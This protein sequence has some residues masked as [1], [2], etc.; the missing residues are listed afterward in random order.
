MKTTSYQLFAQLCESFVVEVSSTANII[1]TLK[2]GNQVLKYLHSQQGLGHEQQ[3]KPIAKIAWSDLKDAY[4]GA[5]VI[6]QY[7]NGVGAIKQDRGSYYAVA[8]IGGEVKAYDDTRGGNILNFLKSEL[9]GNPVKM[10][11]GTETGKTKELKSKRKGIQQELEKTTVMNQD[12]LVQKFSPLW[13][14]AMTA[15]IADIKGMVSNMIKND[16]FEKAERKLSQLKR[17]DQGIMSLEAGESQR[18]D[19]LNSA[20]SQAIHMAAAHYYPDETG[21]VTKSYHGYS[22]QRP[23]GIQMLL[24]D[25]SSGDQKKLGAILSFFKRALI[26]G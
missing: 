1:G 12:T 26:T 18:P 20:I 24:K 4:R 3:Y 21:E 10:W 23:E 13:N 8:S 16:A 2:G 7:K 6:M 15:A 5:W 25:V 14:K 17:L 22:S 19:F 9:G 11:S